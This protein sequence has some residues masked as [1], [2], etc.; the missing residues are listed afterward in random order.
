[1]RYSGG[2]ETFTKDYW[3]LK[4]GKRYQCDADSTPEY[5]EY[6]K[7]NNILQY[8]KP[9]ESKKFTNVH[10]MAYWGA[11]F[12]LIPEPKESDHE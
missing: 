12:R 1:M 7:L 9:G 3:G 11:R 10:N 8:R 2:G 4:A 5:F 6:R